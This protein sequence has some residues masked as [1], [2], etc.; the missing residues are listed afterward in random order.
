MKVNVLV[1]L[2]AA[3]MSLAAIADE[4]KTGEAKSAETAVSAQLVAA[5][6]DISKIIEN[7]DTMT[8]VIKTLSAEEQVKFLA[9]V[10]AAIT[11]LPG[12]PEQK[13][14]KFVSVDRAALKGAKEGNMRA[15]V[16][17]IFASVPPEHLTVIADRYSQD[18]FN[19]A[20]DP[21][22]TYTDSQY[23]ELAAEILQT[24]EDRLVDVDHHEVRG[25]MAAIMLIKASNS[26][27]EQLTDTLVAKLPE[28]VR[29]VAKEEWI[30]S[31][32]GSD[33]RTAS[34]EPLL[35]AADAGRRPDPA[36]I[37]VVNGPQLMDTM[38]ADLTGKNVDPVAGINARTPV[39]DAVINPIKVQ[40]P[41]LGSDSDASS[42][43]APQQGADADKGTGVDP[44]NPT[45][46]PEP[47]PEPEP[48][49]YGWQSTNN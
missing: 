42:K 35:A 9:E 26:N 34:Y 48:G 21:K 16:A 43:P 40:V 32:L 46:T 4:P 13:A 17:E 12:S 25:T 31:A 41:T 7:P 29:Q 5:R 14:A 44:V 20:A 22:V 11:E 8:E 38:L 15:M 33:G 45:P 39:V 36:M 6:A 10:N 2:L 27:A 28:S 37:I 24:V 47:E 18:L 49:P 23:T 1:A 19:R 3:A 30:P